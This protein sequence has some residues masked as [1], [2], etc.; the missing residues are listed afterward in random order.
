M[1]LEAKSKA[2]GAGIARTAL[3]QTRAAPQSSG[4]PD[5]ERSDIEHAP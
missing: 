1:L 3:E 4:F 2:G 5:N